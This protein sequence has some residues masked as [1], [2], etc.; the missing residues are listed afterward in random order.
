MKLEIYE[1]ALCCSTGVCGPE[2]D[3][4]LID[5]QNTL[6]L[7]K[8]AGVEVQRYA[9]NQSPLAFTKNETVKAFIKENG[10]GKLPLSL[11]DG[12]V[13]NSGDY[14]SLEILKEKIPALKEVK[15]DSKILGQFS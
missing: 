2:P 8:K 1:P 10:P 9:I 5:L 6:N 13:L 12:E 14:P 7:L 11:L 3:K 15:T 4:Q